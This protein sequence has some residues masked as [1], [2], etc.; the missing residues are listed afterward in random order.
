M[1]LAASLELVQGKALP[2]QTLLNIESRTQTS[3]RP[4][5]RRNV[6]SI[7]FGPGRR[8]AAFSC[9]LASNAPALAEYSNSRR[10]GFSLQV[11]PR[12]G[13][14]SVS[15]AALFH[16][17]VLFMPWPSRKAIMP[18]LSCRLRHT[19]LASPS[20]HL[21]LA[22][23]ASVM[24]ASSL[25]LADKFSSQLAC[26]L[27]HRRLGRV[28][29]SPLSCDTSHQPSLRIRSASHGSLHNAYK[30][31]HRAHGRL[32]S[33]TMTAKPA[34]QRMP[35]RS[36]NE[37][38]A[39]LR[40]PGPLESML[41]KTTETG[42]I[43][44]FTIRGGMPPPGYHQ[45]PRS[46][47]NVANAD[48]PLGPPARMYE[49][50]RGQDERKCL[51]TYRDTTSEI[52]SL[53]GSDN[54]QQYG[55]SSTSP[56]AEDGHRSYSLTTCS[57][58]RIPSQKSSGTLQSQSSGGYGSLRRSQSPFPYPTRLKRPG[59]RT[60]SQPM[61][62]NGGVDYSRTGE[63]N[64]VSQRTTYGASK[65]AYAHGPR[66]PPPLSLR[67]DANRSTTSLPSGVSPGPY[68]FGPGHIR[69][70]SSSVSGRSRPYDRH[71]GSSVDH[72]PRSASLTS[73][74]EM[75]QRPATASSAVPA[76][77]PG[78]SF[79]Y[80]YT[81][82]FEKPAP[83]APRVERQD[84][85][86]PVPQRAGD[87]SRPMV[88]RED[89]QVHLD[90]ISPSIGRGHAVTARTDQGLP[91]P[92]EAPGVEMHHR[93]GRRPSGR[94]AGEALAGA[95]PLSSRPD[96]ATV[97]GNGRSSGPIEKGST[98]SGS[99]LRETHDDAL[100]SPP[101]LDCAQGQ[102]KV[103]P[104][105]GQW[106]LPKPFPAE[107]DVSQGQ[108]AS[109]SSL[110]KSR[111]TLDPALSEFASL[112]SSFDRLAKSPFSHGD[113]EPSTAR[114]IYSPPSNEDDGDEGDVGQDNNIPGEQDD[115][116]RL[117]GFP[118]RL[119]RRPSLQLFNELAAED[120]AQK[121][122][123]RR[124]AAAL[125]INTAGLSDDG[126]KLSPPKEEL[127]IICPEPISPA[128]QL[129]VTKSIPQLMKALPPLPREAAG[130]SER[131]GHETREP[132]K[133]YGKDLSSG[134]KTGGDGGS[135]SDEACA[136]PLWNAQEAGRA[137][138][139]KLKLRINPSSS[140]SGVSDMD[141]AC[142]GERE[143]QAGPPTKSNAGAKPRLKLK[144]SRSR[145]GQAQAGLT[146]QQPNRL[147]QCNSLA[148]LAVRRN[149]AEADGRRNSSAGNGGWEGQMADAD[150]AESS[151]SPRPS[152]QFNIPYPPCPEKSELLQRGSTSSGKGSVGKAHS[153]T[154][155]V[156]P[157][158]R[159]GLRQKLSMFRLRI[160][161]G[162]GKEAESASGVDSKGASEA[163]Q[164]M[165][166]GSDQARGRAIS[167][168]RSDRMGG[169][170]KRWASDAKQA[171]RLYV[172]RRLD[173]SSRMS[174]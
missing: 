35:L 41:K 7:G 40:S 103:M 14:T 94:S 161:G 17:A 86:C 81:E 69:T 163:V 49:N 8:G 89:S 47:P 50:G 39:L 122:R 76:L 78:G 80:D 54:N 166:D 68:N 20:P 27:T 56:T 44:L 132:P 42:D 167:S 135:L 18:R 75:Y 70:P 171:V 118:N 25:L 71:R 1:A 134:T 141:T 95:D 129:K 79:Y 77:R 23:R 110:V 136:C 37:N 67:A 59:I 152:D 160:T 61:A 125:R 65:A 83:L 22:T 43:G 92:V 46:R 109:R 58:Q 104:A 106:L 99:E 147:K 84:P 138:P 63:L 62:E 90:T 156:G 146:A 85:L 131:D 124:N 87:G 32:A 72:S 120:H 102:E 29:T 73:I 130:T 169:R 142:S 137:S 12:R 148:D 21:R 133:Y 97:S 107:A 127:A 3:P 143:R 155:E 93:H 45:P 4:L 100:A 114:V 57:S 162:P 150:R 149:E 153:F 113:G 117:G 105:H 174:G 51:R 28:L 82:E 9:P 2:G 159:R 172:R 88:L 128:R 116:V 60:P 126:Q 96:V 48:M 157:A 34:S 158:E 33:G 119:G 91:A 5:H 55:P 31:A 15:R 170:V 24:P 154:W 66:R 164:S 139:L 64:R 173:R 98:D 144:V 123:H 10:H 30:D 19:S 168:T 145:L 165:G 52:I 108:R 115:K 74:V 26:T 11:S 111:N 101:G 36:V 121:R 140:P 112:F 6:A 151:D 13:C 16:R 53:Y 38:A